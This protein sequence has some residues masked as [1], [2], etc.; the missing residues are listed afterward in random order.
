MEKI[1]SAF[2]KAIQAEKLTIDDVPIIYK[3]A[4][5]RLLQEGVNYE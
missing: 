1:I 2:V 4:V 5:T 3:E